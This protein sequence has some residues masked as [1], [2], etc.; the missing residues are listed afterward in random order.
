MLLFG[1]L[2]LLTPLVVA[3]T[4]GG[5]ALRKRLNRHRV[6]SRLCRD[7]RHAVATMP[8]PPSDVVPSPA[9]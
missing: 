8:P 2:L 5:P 1:L 9:D 3:A 6:E 4:V 7:I